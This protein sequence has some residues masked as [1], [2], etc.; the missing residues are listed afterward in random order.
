MIQGGVFERFPG[1]RVGYLE[2]NCSWVPFWLWR[3]D[4]HW[5]TRQHIKNNQL[6]KPPS[7]YFK[8]HC[9]VGIEADEVPGKYA[10]DWGAGNNIVFS[11]DFPHADSRFP[12]AVKQFVELPLAEEQKRKILWDNCVRLY[13]FK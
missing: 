9:Y 13:N 12:G 7:E 4:E 6:K 2:G 3:M 11:T 5:E 8:Q 10:V 1:L